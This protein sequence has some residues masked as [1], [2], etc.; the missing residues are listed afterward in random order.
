MADSYVILNHRGE[1]VR[2]VDEAALQ[3]LT[4]AGEGPLRRHRCELMTPEPERQHFGSGTLIRVG[5][6]AYVA[7]AAHLFKGGRI[8]HLQVC[9]GD[10]S[11]YTDARGVVQMTNDIDVDVAL[12]SF[13][14]TENERVVARALPLHQLDVNVRTGAHDLFA[15]CGVP[16][17]G[18]K[19]NSDTRTIQFTSRVVGCAA[20]DPADWPNLDPPAQRDRDIFLHYSSRFGLDAD[21]NEQGVVNPGGMSGGGVWRVPTKAEG[22]WSPEAAQLAGIQRSVEEDDWNWLR[23]TRIQHWL[24]LVWNVEPSSQ[25]AILEALPN[26]EQEFPID[27]PS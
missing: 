25:A 14:E 7:T 26:F 20:M 10:D 9:V 18:F 8:K 13:D 5:D 22:V 21:G 15:V 24:R 19:V 11:S 12:L 4:A 17:T 2:E 1:V 3:A 16:E 27:V 23:A 6:Q